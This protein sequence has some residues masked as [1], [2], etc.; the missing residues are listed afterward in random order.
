MMFAKMSP[1]GEHVAFVRD[2]N[3]FIEDLFDHS[4]RQLT[5]RIR[6][7]S[8]TARPIGCTKKSWTA[9]CVSVDS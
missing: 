4:I 5:D 8:S 1:T 2:R 9:R 6:T 7:T 3:I